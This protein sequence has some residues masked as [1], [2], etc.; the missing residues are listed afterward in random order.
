MAYSDKPLTAAPELIPAQH[1]PRPLALFGQLSLQR[2]L[3]SARALRRSTSEPEILSPDLFLASP[4]QWN[5]ADLP[6][7]GLAAWHF[8]VMPL[9][10]T[11]Q[12]FLNRSEDKS[13]APS[14]NLAFAATQSE[15]LSRE[16]MDQQPRPDGADTQFLLDRLTELLE[17]TN[18]GFSIE[19][20]LTELGPMRAVRLSLHELNYLQT[21]G[22]LPPDLSVG[23]FNERAKAI[24]KALASK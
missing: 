13:T 23:R 16:A 8:I 18:H 14:M 24:A 6:S 19:H 10:H 4:Q 9:R 3:A 20:H 17:K 2:A 1:L 22:V 21:L 11:E 7:M 5:V 15:R 12:H